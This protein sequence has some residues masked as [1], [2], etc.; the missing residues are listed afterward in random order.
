MEEQRVLEEVQLA[1]QEVAIRLLL[2]QAV[3]Y[4]VSRWSSSRGIPL[5]EL[6]ENQSALAELY[7]KYEDEAS[8]KNKNKSNN[9]SRQGSSKKIFASKTKASKADL[10]EDDD[11][12]VSVSDLSEALE[13][14]IEPKKKSRVRGKHRLK[15][16]T[17]T[18]Q[19]TNSLSEISDEEFDYDTDN[20]NDQSANAEESSCDEAYTTEDDSSVQDS[21][22]V[23]EIYTIKRPKRKF[24]AKADE[25]SNSNQR[26][27]GKLTKKLN[28]DDILRAE[29]ANMA[30]QIF[31]RIDNSELS[32][33]L[34]M[35]LLIRPNNNPLFTL[36]L[37]RQPIDNLAAEKFL[38]IK[39]STIQCWLKS[40]NPI[41]KIF[42]RGDAEKLIFKFESMKKKLGSLK[43]NPDMT[44]LE[45]MDPSLAA[46]V[47][48]RFE[49]AKVDVRYKSVYQSLASNEDQYVE[50][51][52]VVPVNEFESEEENQEYR[53]VPNGC[54]HV[55]LNH[56]GGM[57]DV[58]RPNVFDP[59]SSKFMLTST[60]MLEE[61]ERVLVE[62]EKINHID[63]E[64]RNNNT[65]PFFDL[66]SDKSKEIA[67]NR[68]NLKADIDETFKTALMN[69][70][71]SGQFSPSTLELQH[72]SVPSLALQTAL[73]YCGV[74]LTSLDLS[75][76]TG[77]DDKT[78]R[79][80]SDHCANL[81]ALTMRSVAI[82][83][84]NNKLPKLRLL[85]L[86]S[87]PSFEDNI[88]KDLKKYCQALD[89]LILSET[90]VSA[91]TADLNV[92]SLDLSK[93]SNITDD[94]FTQ[95]KKYCKKLISLS[96]KATS[97]TTVDLDALELS[98]LDVSSCNSVTQLSTKK[99]RQNAIMAQSKLGLVSLK[100]NNCRLLESIL[101]YDT[102]RLFSLSAK[103]CKNLSSVRL[104]PRR[105]SPALE[106]IDLDQNTSLEVLEVRPFNL[107]ILKL[108]NCFHITTPLSHQ[109]LELL[110]M[111]MASK[112]TSPD[113]Q[114]RS[115]FAAGLLSRN[116]GSEFLYF[117]KSKNAE[118]VFCG[119]DLSGMDA[120][121]GNWE[122]INLR[123]ANLQNSRWNNAYITGTIFA[124]ARMDSTFFGQKPF[125][126]DHDDSICCIEYSPN[127]ML[128]ATGYRDGAVIVRNHSEV[129]HNFK[130]SGYAS[131]VSFSP[132]GRLLAVGGA[133]INREESDT[134]SFEDYGN[135]FCVVV[136]NLRHKDTEPSCFKT[137]LKEINAVA[138]S[139]CGNFLATASVDTSVKIRNLIN[140][141]IQR[142][143]LHKSSVSS[144]SWCPQGRYLA[145]GGYD[146]N[147]II[148]DT[149]EEFD[150][151][152]MGGDKY[153]GHEKQINDLTYS[154]NG[155]FIV[156]NSDDKTVKVW[157]TTEFKCLKTLDGHRRNPEC[158]AIS[159][160]SKL[161][162]S[163]ESLHKNCKV[164][165]WDAESGKIIQELGHKGGV[166]TLA[167]KPGLE[168]P[169][170]GW[171][172]L[173]GSG[174][175]IRRWII[176][177]D[178]VPQGLLR[179]EQYSVLDAAM[180]DISNVVG[181]SE[182]NAEL[183]HQL[184]AYGKT[185]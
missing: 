35:E 51:Y 69:V 17:I 127:G 85:D 24:F 16:K 136:F 163:G 22:S 14:L 145:S 120:S 154:P 182:E 6:L 78:L 88:F 140:N 116:L 82:S 157:D 101:L 71:R 64:F 156:S 49:V 87:C 114:M 161:I 151:A 12:E 111:Q 133:I 53:I 183:L 57:F 44:Y 11:D 160:D 150:V 48:A 164:I 149:E 126:E 158:V 168:R 86:S 175:I 46:E 54:D 89:A 122:D 67:V 185:M 146:K 180:A 121:S 97:I 62:W 8:K 65:T 131:S 167:F 55:V 102:S 70:L 43:N 142:H 68:L 29:K 172:L 147:I 109:L 28:E 159:P 92:T 103:N 184:N 76:N 110:F 125:Y 56:S 58:V 3:G 165:I 95:L 15:N 178:L 74:R 96:L 130:V 91:I 118:A 143:M 13:D 25:S 41:I 84:I 173:T 30:T 112:G 134:L 50:Q 132:D 34:L 72:L 83:K 115:A 79:V 60:E 1:A 152:V 135:D 174:E 93:C 113:V 42:Y 37:V 144:L 141:D 162:A 117:L 27:N 75:Y 2:E 176:D 94:I 123:G 21:V 80:I 18:R 45:L 128:M 119:K 137:H 31:S 33:L 19:R 26:D 73:S 148:W 47:K 39:I 10:E 9:G 177:S 153:S 124:N 171:L 66:K 98:H 38:D 129:I 106:V 63:R 59:K 61:F 169:K 99:Q 108:L 107:K 4:N 23:S 181:L 104:A 100:A 179:K 81:V 155:K 40:L 5:T 52:M 139:P 138:F 7:A 90:H 105:S 77:V 166:S 20:Y 170:E 36:N 32:L